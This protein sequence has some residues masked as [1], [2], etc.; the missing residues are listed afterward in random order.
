M[1]N[2]PLSIGD[3]NWA[4]DGRE[5]GIAKAWKDNVLKMESFAETT[6]QAAVA[7]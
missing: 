6:S 5:G 3:E 2:S 4:A 1:V 7:Q